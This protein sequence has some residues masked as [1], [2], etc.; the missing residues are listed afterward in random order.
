MLVWRELLGLNRWRR[1]DNCRYS[2]HKAENL[3]FLLLFGDSLLTSSFFS[4]YTAFP[5]FSL[6][7]TSFSC[8]S[9]SSSGFSLAL[10]PSVAPSDCSVLQNCALKPLQSR[11][12]QSLP[13]DQGISSDWIQLSCFPDFPQPQQ[14]WPTQCQKYFL[15]GCACQKP[16]DWRVV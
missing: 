3:C 6:H 8:S 4:Q 13:W 1:L 14:I 2:C 9:C 16:P 7:S 12:E 5:P 15:M 11:R 10:S